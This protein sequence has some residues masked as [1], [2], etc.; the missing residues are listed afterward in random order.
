[1]K[2]QPS[3]SRVDS[4]IVK[5]IR[6]GRTEDFEKLVLRWQKP[7]FAVAV[8]VGVPPDHAADA[9]QEAFVRA[10]R[11]IESLRDP[12]SFGP[13]FLAIVRNV[14]RR[15]LAD[16][17]RMVLSPNVEL[18]AESYSDSFEKRE[19]NRYVWSKVDAL[20]EALREALVLYYWEGESVRSVARALGTTAAAVKNRLHKGREILRERL[21]REIGTSI[22]DMLPSARE[23]KRGARRVSLIAI[24]S[25]P[26]AW[27]PVAAAGVHSAATTAVSSVAA[28]STVSGGL[29]LMSGKV[30]PSIAIG[31]VLLFLTGF[32]AGYSMEEPRPENNSKAPTV[33]ATET[34]ARAAAPQTAND[35]GS[36]SGN[37]VDDAPAEVAVVRAPPDEEVTTGALRVSAVW[38]QTNE[39]AAGVRIEV[40]PRGTTFPRYADLA[41]TTDDRGVAVIAAVPAGIAT[42]RADR[43]WPRGHVRASRAEI[44][45]GET[46]E[47]FLRLEDQITVAGRVVD[48]DGRRVPDAEIWL[49]RSTFDPHQSARIS[50]SDENGEFSLRGVESGR[51]V[52]A[53]KDGF[54]PSKIHAARGESGD[55]MVLEL[56]LPGRGGAVAGRVFAPDRSPVAG[57]LVV[58][59]DRP[60]MSGAYIAPPAPIALRSDP[61]GAFAL[62]GLQ[63]GRVP[64][65]VRAPGLAPRDTFVDVQAGVEVEVDI[66]LEPGASLAGRVTDASGS[67]IERARVEVAVVEDPL[68]TNPVNTHTWTDARGDFVIEGLAAGPTPV[69]ISARGRQSYRESVELA[70]GETIEIDVELRGTVTLRGRVVFEDGNPMTNGIVI[71]AGVWEKLDREGRFSVE[72][73]EERDYSLSVR[74]RE[75]RFDCFR[76]DVRPS[77]EEITIVVP[78]ENRATAFVAGKILDADGSAVWKAEVLCLKKDPWHESSVRSGFFGGFRVGPLPPGDYRVAAKTSAGARTWLT[79]TI[80]VEA[81]ESVDVGEFKL[82]AG[83]ALR[84]EFA[85][86]ARQEGLW[87]LVLD[88][89]DLPV[90]ADHVT[91]ERSRTDPVVAGRYRVTLRRGGKVAFEQSVE[92]EADAETV[93]RVGADDIADDTT[94]EEAP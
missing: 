7:A 80:R 43:A 70:L 57:A 14:A 26:A 89:D 50:A 18:S 12:G 68:R 55:T 9:L 79:R 46:T 3:S 77:E 92:I 17:R 91:A 51:Y 62:A 20:P 42:V 23:W 25:L 82:A 73:V 8:A 47:F 5:S 71:V 59:G 78:E 40:E 10:L 15:Q 58:L 1:M 16:A 53:R 28:E 48:A 21:W 39:P 6:A 90:V 29:L 65:L 83:G 11:E 52:F 75:Q 94:D 54:E 30:A 56:Q 19:F 22:R 38:A 84:T 76:A 13:W 60:G 72:N 64:L 85:P 87:L 66:E 27:T 41:G 86:G 88:S 81:G 44:A 36:R 33:V 74:E 35:L 93:L 2:T 4:A 49:T 34:P 67:P 61:D 24:A 37:R 31:S 69:A 63:P 32:F 45:A